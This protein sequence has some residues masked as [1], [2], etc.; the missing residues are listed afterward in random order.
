MRLAMQAIGNG[1]RPVTLLHG[2]LGAGRNL[3]T[4]ARRW[5]EADPT[6]RFLLPD[7]AGHGASPPL[8]AGADLRA[9]AADVLETARA[10]GVEGVLSIVGHSLGGR[11]ALAARLVAPAE[12]GSV[13]L[14]DI[15]PTALEDAADEGSR[16]MRAL[17]QLPE[18][19]PDRD[20]ARRGLLA[21]GLTTGIVEWLLMNLVAR[22]DAYGWRIDRAALAAFR[23]RHLGADLWPAITHDG[24]TRLVRGARSRYVSVDEVVRLEQAGVLV[25]SLPNAGHFVHVD[26]PGALVDTL[27]R[28]HPD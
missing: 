9:M 21:Q 10:E 23:Q 28:V 6:R 26:A 4:L 27:V 16:S 7:L 18:I 12:V 17:L 2:F 5:S 11:V 14:L 15:G 13:T 19:V 25:E 20:T 8:S 24:T 1:T 22:D 3:T